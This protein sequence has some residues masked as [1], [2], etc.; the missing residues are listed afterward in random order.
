VLAK[1][2][3]AASAAV[4][5]SAKRVAGPALTGSLLAHSITG[6]GMTANAATAATSG[7][8]R[9]SVPVVTSE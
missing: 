9:S 6:P 5:T 4:A 1:A 2:T 3:V 7:S 8:G